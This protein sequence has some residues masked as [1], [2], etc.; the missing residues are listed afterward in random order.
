M[1]KLTLLLSALMLAGATYAH[2]GKSACCK[3]KKE[4]C[5][6]E[7]KDK[8]ACEKKGCCAKKDVKTAKK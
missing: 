8:A 7:A 2:E 5:K 3:G 6:K 1:K 4:A